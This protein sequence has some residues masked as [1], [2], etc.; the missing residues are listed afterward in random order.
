VIE[1]KNRKVILSAEVIADGVVTAR[2]ETVMVQ[3]KEDPAEGA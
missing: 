3:I 2:G 1:I